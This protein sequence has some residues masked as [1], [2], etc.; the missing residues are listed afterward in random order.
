MGKRGPKPYPAAMMK[1]LGCSR[2]TARSM[3]EAGFS[4]SPEPPSWM[5]GDALVLWRRV[6]PQLQQIGVVA[7][8]DTE[9]LSS[10]CL[11]WQEIV[12]S[13]AK[14]KEH[15]MFVKGAGGRPIASP[16]VKIRASAIE[17]FTRLA[18]SFGF[19]PADRTRIGPGNG[20][21]AKP[22]GGTSDTPAFSDFVKFPQPKEAASGRDGA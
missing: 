5:E 7:D 21:V 18:A 13:T 12:E 17:R 3:Q 20:M 16:A 19:T 6:V 2:A 15:G 1:A 22:N 9:A 4:G 14:I 11:C 10:L 8:V